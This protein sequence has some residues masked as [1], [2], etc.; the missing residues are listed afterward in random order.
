MLQREVLQQ[1]LLIG[2][3]GALGANA[4]YFLARWVTTLCGDKFPWATFVIN[5]SGSFI[6]GLVMALSAPYLKEEIG[7]HIRLGVAVGFIGAYTT[8]STF[9]YETFTLWQ[10]SSLLLSL[11]NVL[12][13]LVCGF[14]AVWSGIILGE[15]I[16]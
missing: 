6:L 14:V 12:G 3:G 1:V 4:R 10:S 2:T 9:E 13:S 15:V 11:L 16:R 7:Q 8:F 5:I